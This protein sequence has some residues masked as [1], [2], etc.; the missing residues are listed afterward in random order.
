ML[1]ANE[2]V[3]R[4]NVKYSCYFRSLALTFGSFYIYV[5]TNL[6]YIHGITID[7]IPNKPDLDLN[8]YTQFVYT[9]FRSPT[10]LLGTDFIKYNNTYDNGVGYLGLEDLERL[11]TRLCEKYKVPTKTIIGAKSFCECCGIPLLYKQDKCWACE[12]GI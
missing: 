4:S 6:S 7:S 11:Y 5:G 8:E 9:L 1:Y 3:K 12:R 10:E 2:F